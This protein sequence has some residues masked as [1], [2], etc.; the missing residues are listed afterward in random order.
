MLRR[1][2]RH[3]MHVP[4]FWR[5]IGRV[6]NLLATGV[7]H[8]NYLR[9]AAQNYQYEN[10]RTTHRIKLDYSEKSTHAEEMAVDKLKINI[11]PKLINIS[12]LVI[13]ITS[14]SNPN[15]YHLVNSRPCIACMYKLIHVTQLGYRITKIYFSNEVGEIICYKLRDI[16]AEKHHASR[17]YRSSSIPKKFL[18]QFGLY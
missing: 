6:L 17:Y 18:K 10:K 16:M 9:T 1:K 7:N 15:C 2:G 8:E 5:K 13:R 3:V 12:L 11:K 14:G 4:S